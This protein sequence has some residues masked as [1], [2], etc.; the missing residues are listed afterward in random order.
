MTG[1]CP[2]VIRFAF[3]VCRLKVPLAGADAVG[4]RIRHAR[5]ESLCITRY[6]I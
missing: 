3:G 2:V 4:T 6:S 5:R 1:L